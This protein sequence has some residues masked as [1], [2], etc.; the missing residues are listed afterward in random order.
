MAGFLL[1]QPAVEAR[2]IELPATSATY[3]ANDL[4]ELVGGTTTWA[5]TTSSTDHFTRKAIVTKGGT[6]V[7]VIWAIPLTGNELVLAETA[8]NSATTERGDRMALTDENTVNNSGTDVTGQA[9]AFQQIGEI[10]AA[11]DKRI[12]G[13][14][15]VGNGV[16]T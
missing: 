5:K 12:L 2:A 4:V 10:G 15:L 16:D 1:H 3:V 13:L 11:A 7:T 14:V 8:N 6:T 9:V